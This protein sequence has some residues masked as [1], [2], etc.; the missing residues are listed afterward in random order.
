[1]WVWGG[2][3]AEL[4]W[5][6]LKLSPNADRGPHSWVCSCTPMMHILTWMFTKANTHMALC[7][8][9]LTILIW[10]QLSSFGCNFVILQCPW[11]ILKNEFESLCILMHHYISFY[12]KRRRKLVY[13]WI[14]GWGRNEISSVASIHWYSS[15]HS[16]TWDKE[17]PNISLNVKTETELMILR[18]SV[19]LRPRLKENYLWIYM[20]KTKAFHSC[21]FWSYIIKILIFHLN[22]LQL[23]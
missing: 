13:A 22:Y 3:G 19:L 21:L 15:S 18:I 16:K 6:Q 2:W 12:F 11:V 17:Y 23:Q 9:I 10:S 8:F 4:K 14:Y 20:W 5:K 1:M 7:G